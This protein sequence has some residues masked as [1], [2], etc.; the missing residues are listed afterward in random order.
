MSQPR[1]HLTCIQMALND[2]HYAPQLHIDERNQCRH[3]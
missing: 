2:T 1:E 3:R